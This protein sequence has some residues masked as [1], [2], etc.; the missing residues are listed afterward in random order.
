MSV[1]CRKKYRLFF[2][3]ILLFSW[4]LWQSYI[5]IRIIKCDVHHLQNYAEKQYQRL[6]QSSSPR[7][8]IYDRNHK[9]LAGN[10]RVKSAFCVPCRAYKDNKFMLF[11]KENYPSV[12]ERILKKPQSQFCFIKR[13]IDEK[14]EQELL[15]FHPDFCHFVHE[16]A[17]YYPFPELSHVVGAVDI[18]LEGVSGLEY[19]FRSQ[20]KSS[21]SIVYA[22]KDARGTDGTFSEDIRSYGKKGEDCF[23]FIDA[24]LNYI[25][26]EELRKTVAAFNSKEAS[27]FIMDP[28]SGEVLVMAQYPHYSKKISDEAIDPLDLFKNKSISESYEIGSLM[29]AFCILAA[30]SEKVVDIDEM[31]DCRN[32]RTAFINGIKVN[33]VKAQGIVPFKEVVQLSNNIGI[34]QIALRMGKNLYSHYV[35]LGFGDQ[36]GIELPGEAA[37]FVMP[38]SRWSK[39]TI[40]S[41]SYGYEVMV[42]LAQI[43]SAWSVMVNN[44]ERII[45]RITNAT[46][47]KKTK[48][49]YSDDVIQKALSVM[50]Y[51]ELSA[52]KKLLIKFPECKIFG[53]TGTA[54]ILESGVYNPHRN[55]YAFVGH[56][57]Y[58]NF[59]R[60]I[61]V[62]VRESNKKNIYASTVALPLFLSI[63]EKILIQF[64]LT[65]NFFSEVS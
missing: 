57:E 25:V 3:A 60:I 49:I 31:I 37:G 19:S 44:G 20:L 29:K 7:G 40:F 27:A 64:Q 63:A 16:Y 33:T 54:N 30:F 62:Y 47:Y 5:L 10:K 1:I 2:V 53:K 45:P 36:I 9:V 42:T 56:I 58:G 61:V 28:L 48:Q 18:D 23:T 26:T 12:H 8:R 34:A 24:D 13:F 46:P 22:E 35:N 50:E 43:A 59:K 14:E 4:L 17:R 55:T 32:S 51:N 65:N 11:L 41:L 6:I 38:P 39:Q 15:L 52:A 21:K